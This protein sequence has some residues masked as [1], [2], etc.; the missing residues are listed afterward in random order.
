M[1]ISTKYNF[2]IFKIYI[3]Y[4]WHCFSFKIMYPV[5][6][7]VLQHFNVTRLITSITTFRKTYSTIVMVKPNPFVLW[8]AMKTRICVL[9]F[10][11]LNNANRENLLILG[12]NKKVKTIAF[13]KKMHFCI[14]IDKKTKSFLQLLCDFKFDVHFYFIKISST[15]INLKT[16]P[17]ITENNNLDLNTFKEILLLNYL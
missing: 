8:W 7:L 12:Q 3:L 1:I 9:L 2:I 10:P 15:L 11:I 17:F 6:F 4:M 16:S 13:L 5:K 14:V